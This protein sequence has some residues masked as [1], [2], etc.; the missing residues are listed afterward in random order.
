MKLHGLQTEPKYVTE[1]KIGLR[2][3]T[4]GKFSN[5]NP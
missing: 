3:L 5:I 2:E 4:T 1:V